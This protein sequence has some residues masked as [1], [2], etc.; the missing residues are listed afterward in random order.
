MVIHNCNPKFGEF[1]RDPQ[2]WLRF[3]CSRVCARIR[4]RHRTPSSTSKQAGQLYSKVQSRGR[5]PA[6]L[7]SSRLL[8]CLVPT[9][10][11]RQAHAQP[12]KP[13]SISSDR[14]GR[15]GGRGREATERVRDSASRRCGRG[16]ERRPATGP[17]MERRVMAGRQVA[18]HRWTTVRWDPHSVLVG[19]QIRY[20]FLMI[21]E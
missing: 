14:R 18:S 1:V 20:A 7:C 12:H 19:S 6:Q 17:T 8:P 4:P 5:Q 16:S 11:T 9:E 10:S 3:V 2:F 21:S 13:L 15:R